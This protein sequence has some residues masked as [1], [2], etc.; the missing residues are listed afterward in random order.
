MFNGEIS[1]RIG[2]YLDFSISEIFILSTNSERSENV[3]VKPPIHKLIIVKK[4]HDRRTVDKK[5]EI[6]DI[7]VNFTNQ[8]VQITKAQVYVTY[9]KRGHSNNT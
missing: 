5:S 3:S 4:Q 6:N 8:M 7:W 2:S 9:Q 1:I